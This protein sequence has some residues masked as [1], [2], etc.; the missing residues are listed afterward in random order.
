MNTEGEGPKRKRTD[1]T[2]KNNRAKELQRTVVRTTLRSLCRSRPVLERIEHT[3]CCANEAVRGAYHIANVDTLR[4]LELSK[5][6][7]KY[8]AIYFRNCLQASVLTSSGK[9]YKSQ[10]KASDEDFSESVIIAVQSM[11]RSNKQDGF[12]CVYI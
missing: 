6:L 12:E 7:P 10:S 1:I 9:P 3:V 5:Q 8:D 11:E 4:R 2:E